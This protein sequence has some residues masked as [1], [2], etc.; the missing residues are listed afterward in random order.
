[1]VRVRRLLL[2]L[3][4]LAVFVGG[5]GGSTKT[6]T[7]LR[8]TAVAAKP[9]SPQ[10]SPCPPPPGE[11]FMGVCAPSPVQ[12]FPGG[13]TAPLLANPSGGRFVDVSSWQGK[14]NWPAVVNWQRQHG[15]HVGG[16]FKMG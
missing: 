2:P 3:V 5:C 12:V 10:T 9:H 8:P 7:A 4:G 11:G 6:V 16:V 14:V 15:W 1:M 13:V